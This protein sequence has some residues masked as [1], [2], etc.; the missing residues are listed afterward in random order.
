MAIILVFELPVKDS[1]KKR[2]WRPSQNELKIIRGSTA[3]FSRDSTC[4]PLTR[5]IKSEIRGKTT[6]HTIKKMPNTSKRTKI[7]TLHDL[8]MSTE[9]FADPN[10][11]DQNF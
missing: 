4:C 3:D 8:G 1:D 2:F 11:V 6:G 10:E 7:G 5:E 9:V